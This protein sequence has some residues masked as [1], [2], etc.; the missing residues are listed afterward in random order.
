MHLSTNDFHIL[1]A[2]D[3]EEITSQRQL[4]EHTGIS[5]GQVN[6]VVKRLLEKGLVKIGNFQRNPQKIGY[7]YLLTPKGFEAK[8]KMA[9]RFV[10]AQLKKYNVLQERLGNRLGEIAEMGVERIVFVGP[11]M[12]HEFVESIIE[13]KDLNLKLEGH[14]TDVFKLKEIPSKQYGAALLFDEEAAGIKR[15]T[16]ETGIPQEKLIPLW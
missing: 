2:L 16:A 4:S 7:A 8:S 9:V 6:Y 5:L 13:K 14:I 12:V 10:M 15:L 1:D 11:V 3:A